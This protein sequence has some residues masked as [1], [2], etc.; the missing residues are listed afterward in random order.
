MKAGRLS[1]EQIDASVVGGSLYTAGIV[2]PDLL[3]RTANERRVSNFLL[4]Q[5]ASAEYYVTPTYW[6]DFDK[7][8]LYKALLT[9]G[10]RNRRFGQV[11][12]R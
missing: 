9:Y 11:Q 8:E 2:D 1:P 10:Q 12:Q 3:I 6:P 5:A 4:W 7:E